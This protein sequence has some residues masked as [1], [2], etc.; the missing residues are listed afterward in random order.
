MSYY[1]LFIYLNGGGSA[2]SAEL[3]MPVKDFSSWL[4]HMPL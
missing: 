2:I 4:N 1:T 3:K